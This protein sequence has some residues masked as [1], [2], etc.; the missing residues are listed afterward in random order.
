MKFIIPLLCISLI[1][2]YTSDNSA[3]VSIEN[4]SDTGLVIRKWHV[5]GPFI[6]NGEKDY[7]AKDNLRAF[8]LKESSLTFDEFK[9]IT[10]DTTN[11]PDSSRILNSL[12]EFP[13]QLSL[14][15]K[16]KKGNVYVSCIIRSD[17]KVRLRLN[18]F[19]YSGVKVWLNQRLIPNHGIPKQLLTYWHYLPLNLNKGDNFLL[20]KVNNTSDEGWEMHPSI[21]KESKAG[22]WRHEQAIITTYNHDFLESGLITDSVSNNLMVNNEFVP[23]S[24]QLKLSDGKKILFY[25]TFHQPSKWK[26]NLSKLKDGLYWGQ[27]KKGNIGLNQYIF[28]GDI[29]ESTAQLIKSMDQFKMT[30]DIRANVNALILRYHVI[31]KKSLVAPD[32]SGTRGRQVRMLIVYRQLLNVYEQLKANKNPYSHNPG[33]FIR[34]YTSEIDNSTQYYLLHV[35]KSYRKN[36]PLPII[37]NTPTTHT[38][39]PYLESIRVNNSYVILNYGEL[40]NKYNVIVAE[41][42][43]RIRDK[44][45][46][47]TIEETDFFEVLKSVKKDYSIDSS[48]LY[49]TGFC[50]G[51]WG[52]LKLA[53]KYPD[54]IA[55]IAINAAASR[56]T[57]IDNK[58][59][60]SNEPLHYLKNLTNMPI[61]QVHSALDH[62]TPIQLGDRL[63]HEMKRNGLNKVTYN[64]LPT[65]AKYFY[66]EGFEFYNQSF[67]YLCKQNLN[68]PSEVYFKTSQLKNN[69]AYWVI[70]NAINYP[71]E[72]SISARIKDNTLTITTKNIHS[73]SIDLKQ[74]PYIKSKNLRVIENGIEVYNTSVRESTLT[75]NDKVYTLTQKSKNHEVEGPLANIFIKKFTLVTGTLGNYLQDKQIN[76]VA[77]SIDSLWSRRYQTTCIRKKDIDINRNDILNSNL[78]LLGN[79]TS[80]SFIKKV[81]KDI[82]LEVSSSQVKIGSKQMTG[83][84]LGF[85]I[86]YPNPLNPKKYVAIIGYNNPAYVALGLEL[87]DSEKVEDISNYGWFDYKIWEQLNDQNAVKGYFD[88]NWEAK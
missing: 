83:N 36:K 3:V 37:F 80:N 21:E 82:P 29:V 39:T 81:I 47:N 32:K 73:F 31:L 53:A 16:H 58:W 4:L 19:T 11:I 45:N 78:V 10:P 43:G 34:T 30:P 5:L 72:A 87:F 85:Y 46:Y 61:L 6:E 84:K 18:F 60:Q 74:L 75:F 69:K 38:K 44:H 26:L 12:F 15:F 23:D 79:T 14:K 28:K 33:T 59:L 68:I 8:H 77:D 70:L 40:A 50:M 65:S 49:L 17:K 7:F 25:K 27:L 48:R 2:C 54:K 51:S 67:A 42:N 13:R 76:S 62:H 71:N 52:A 35:P 9:N 56:H 22:M 63:N 20:I 41:L 64:R 55:A 1:S 24:Y 66:T 86:I 88:S 57:D